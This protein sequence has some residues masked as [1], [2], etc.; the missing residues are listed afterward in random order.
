MFACNRRHDTVTL[1]VLVAALCIGLGGCDPITPGSTSSVDPAAVA[2]HEEN[3]G[4]GSRR[5]DAG[6]IFADRASYRCLPLAQLS[7]RSAGQIHS[8]ETSCECVE[9]RTVAY[10]GSDGRIADA[11]RLDFVPEDS[12]GKSVP[13]GSRDFRPSLLGVVVT[14]RLVSGETRDVTINNCAG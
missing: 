14:I 9:A 4:V 6:I 3:Q 13:G 1:C 7:I 12:G 5:I 10:R 2:R 8:L 11:L